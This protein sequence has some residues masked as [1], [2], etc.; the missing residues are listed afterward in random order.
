M[1][2]ST[3]AGTTALAMLALSALLSTSAYALPEFLPNP[4]G[5]GVTLGGGSNAL[6]EVQIEGAGSIK[7]EKNKLLGELLTFTHLEVDIHLE[8]CKAIGFQANTPMD[9]P[10]VILTKGLA[11]LCYLNKGLKTVGLAVEVTPTTIIEVPTAKQKLEIT[12]TVI[13][14]VKPVNVKKPTSEVVFIQK[15]GKP[16]IEKCEGAAAAVLLVKESTKAFKPA[17]VET[18]Q[19][20]EFFKGGKA[21]EVEV[22]A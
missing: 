6:V 7:C 4:A 12:G 14:E 21:T 9:S 16:G 3:L 11:L 5:Q 18:T 2:R 1:K 13:G 19:F 22:M 10:G 17:G 15:S 8:G 20:V